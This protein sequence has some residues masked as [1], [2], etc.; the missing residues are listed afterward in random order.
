MKGG[1]VARLDNMSG[2]NGADGPR[3]SRQAP[4]LVAP[5]DDLGDSGE[6]EAGHGVLA[7]NGRLRALKQGRMNNRGGTVSIEPRRTAYVP[8]PSDLV[9]GYIEGCTSN[10]WFVDI[11]GPF[12]AIL[13]MVLVHLRQNLVE[14]ERSSI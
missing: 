10:I 14:S 13:P 11:G 3:R 9:V 1:A 6:Y 4:L 7:I 8:R 12:N 5:G 2:D